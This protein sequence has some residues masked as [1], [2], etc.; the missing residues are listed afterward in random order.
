MHSSLKSLLEKTEE[1]ISRSR[2][3]QSHIT[4]IILGFE[5]TNTNSELLL[6]QIRHIRQYVNEI[7][8]SKSVSS[9]PLTEKLQIEKE[10]FAIRFIGISADKQKYSISTLYLLLE[11]SI[12][13]RILFLP[14]DLDVSKNII[15][16]LIHHEIPLSSFLDQN[17]NLNSSIAFYNK[18]INR[19]NLQI[20]RLND[21]KAL[22]DLFRIC[23]NKVFYQ[24]SKELINK[25]ILSSKNNETVFV[26]TSLLFQ[27]NIQ[28]MVKM[29]SIMQQLKKESEEK[30]VISSQFRIQ[31]LI[32]LSQR[33][34]NLGHN[35]LAFQI[36]LF[37]TRLDKKIEKLPLGWSFDRLKELG[38]EQLLEEA[39]LYAQEKIETLR[40]CCLNDLIDLDFAN[41]QDFDWISEEKRKIEEKI[42]QDFK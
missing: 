38:R 30:K 42:N 36:P 2:K 22:D 19:F 31:Q 27:I 29:V 39:N 11:E 12:N 37:L 24:I 21:R 23:S 32:T 3:D 15:E 18:W 20:L 40:F 26:P 6:H 17:G 4:G 10:S 9:I 5:P 13:D 28:A 14:F 41:K 7:I 16:K 1:S 33:F 8:I 35:Y 25:Q 34:S